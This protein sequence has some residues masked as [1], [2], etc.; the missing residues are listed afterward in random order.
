MPFLLTY[1]MLKISWIKI[2]F[3]FVFLIPSLLF[4]SDYNFNKNCK[5]AYREIINLNFIQAKALIADEKIK[6]PDKCQETIK[7]LRK[8]KLEKI[9]INYG[10]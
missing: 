7:R 1:K 8:Y 10:N 3:G 2:Y 4:A 5:Q 6:N 9:N